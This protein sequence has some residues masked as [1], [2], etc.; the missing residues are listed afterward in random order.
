[1]DSVI[2]KIKDEGH[3]TEELTPIIHMAMIFSIDPG[4]YEAN[5]TEDE[6]ESE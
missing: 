3:T 4:T 6:L 1:M 2:C 5:I